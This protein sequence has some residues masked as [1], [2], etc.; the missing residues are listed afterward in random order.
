[1]RIDPMKHRRLCI[2]IFTPALDA[3]KE[4]GRNMPYDGAVGFAVRGLLL[5]PLAVGGRRSRRLAIRAMRVEL[6]VAKDSVFA[7]R[8]ED[9]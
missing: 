4:P 1:M 9:G 8:K 2:V 5:C 7:A 6:I 3:S